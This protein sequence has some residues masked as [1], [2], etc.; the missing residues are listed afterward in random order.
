M[1]QS[2]RTSFDCLVL[3]DRWRVLTKGGLDDIDDS[4]AGV[5]VGEDLTAAR[6]VLSA[7]L[8]DDDLGLL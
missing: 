4:L 8:E 5:D 7:F 1:K 6:G 2:R 3:G